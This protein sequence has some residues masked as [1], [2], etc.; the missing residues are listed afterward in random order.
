MEAGQTVEIGVT[1]V[2]LA[3]VGQNRA[4]TLVAI[5][6]HQ[7]VGLYVSSPSHATPLDGHTCYNFQETAFL[8]SFSVL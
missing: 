1:A 3:A 2:K 4:G 7:M 6:L 5:V 8:C